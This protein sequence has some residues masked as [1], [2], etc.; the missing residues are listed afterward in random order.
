M[1][2]GEPE[3]LAVEPVEIGCLDQRVAVRG[4][5]AVKLY[6]DDLEAL[7]ASAGEVAQLLQSTPG[8]A[9][10]KVQQVTGFPTL[11]VDFDRAT[12]A[13]YGLTVE[14]VAQSVAIALGGGFLDR[15]QDRLHGAVAQ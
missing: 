6:G 8:S 13:R 14:E 15:G 10:N 9:D 11:D 5:V 3:T 1:K 12:I 2:V 4:D 7:T